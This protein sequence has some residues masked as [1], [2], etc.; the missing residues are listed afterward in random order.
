MGKSI[1]N[2]SFNKKE[3]MII[4]RISEYLKDTDPKYVDILVGVHG[5]E[6]RFVDMYTII[7]RKYN[8]EAYE[9]KDRIILKIKTYFEEVLKA[10][11]D[12]NDNE[13]L[14]YLS[15]YIHEAK[16]TNLGFSVDGCG[17]GFG[18]DKFNVLVNS[19][20]NSAA[21]KS[22]FI[23]DILDVELYVKSIGVDMI[24]DLV[25]N[26][27]QDVLGEY[28]ER[29]LND[30]AMADRLRYNKTHYWD[31]LER[32]WKFKE[33]ATVSYSERIGSKEYNYLLVPICFTSD[34]N[35]KQNIISEIFN[36]YVYDKFK[37]VIL[38]D[39]EKYS[40]YG[41]S[42]DNKNKSVHKKSVVEFLNNEIGQGTAKEGNGYLT[43]K[44]ILDLVKRYDDIKGFIKK[45]IK[46]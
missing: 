5:D 6:K 13:R 30:L 44:G 29:K 36:K 16:Y 42:S 40:K 34:E 32:I 20:K 28:T 23:N 19:I 12:P 4:S 24:S 8:D 1:E 7:H 25:T 33:I 43:S 22:N 21:Y 27:I 45:E 18:E 31:E 3:Y 35:Q 39:E 26:L 9:F 11:S 10:I 2:N 46:A 37:Y 38:N 15:K 17:K 14:R 41:T